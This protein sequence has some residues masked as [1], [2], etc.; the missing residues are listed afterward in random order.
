MKSKKHLEKLTILVY[1][2]Q[3]PGS[4]DANPETIYGAS[5]VYH[6]ES[7]PPPP[8]V[9]KPSIHLLDCM[10]NMEA[11]VVGFIAGH[12]L[13]LTM[14]NKL[15]ALAK[16]LCKDKATLKRLKMHQTTASCKLTYGLS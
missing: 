7:V 5:S 11:M 2:Q 16:E 4:S 13:S 10:T 3:L 12:S 6:G 15:I 8:S 1:T 9:H 14:S